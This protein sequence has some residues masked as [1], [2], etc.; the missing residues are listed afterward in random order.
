MEIKRVCIRSTG[1][2]G[3]LNAIG[4]EHGADYASIYLEGTH[5]PPVAIP[6]REVQIMQQDESESDLPG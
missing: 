2:V 4:T 3:R 5:G 1:Q 6:L